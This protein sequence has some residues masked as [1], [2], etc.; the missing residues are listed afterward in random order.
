MTISQRSRTR[1]WRGVMAATATPLRA[2]L[3]VDF[4]AYADH[5]RQLIDSG[6]D[7]VVPNGSLGEYQTLS[8]EERAR[9]VTTAVEAAGDGARVMAGVA[10]YGSTEARR[11]TEQAAEAGAGSVLLLPPNAYRADEVAVRAHYAEVARAGLPVVAYNNPYDTRTDLSPRLLATLHGEKSIVAVKEFTG[12][13]RRAYEIA[14]LAP[15][16][17]LLIGADDVLV[18]LSLA[19]AVGWIAGFPNALPEACVTLYHA[20]AA[21]NLDMAMPLYRAMHPLLRWDSKPEFVQAIKLSMDVAGLHGGLCRPPR[22]PLSSEDRATV[23]AVT[24]KLLAE[25]LS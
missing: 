1:P 9:L 20:A 18:E 24:E 13:V 19:G 16:L 5:V 11:W 25:G 8:D 6:C 22:S 17:D 15:G 7:G 21:G 23:R 2:D 4:E 10:A 3:S 14:E 12:D